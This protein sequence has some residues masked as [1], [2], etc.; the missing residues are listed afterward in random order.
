[1][2]N[3]AIESLFSD[4]RRENLKLQL[5][6]YK[7]RLNFLC[8]FSALFHKFLTIPIVFLVIVA[9][10]YISQNKEKQLSHQNQVYA[11]SNEHY[12]TIIPWKCVI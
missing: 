5:A 8:V 6:Y 11:F 12:Y 9:V 2:K 1:M 3:G 7:L 10:F 4:L